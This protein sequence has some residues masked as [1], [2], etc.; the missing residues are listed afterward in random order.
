MEAL[1][2][3]KPR[4]MNNFTY[5]YRAQDRKIE[6]RGTHIDLLRVRM[7]QTSVKIY[8]IGGCSTYKRHCYY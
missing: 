7:M 5:D 6:C 1:R 8:R 4:K 2:Y 3:C